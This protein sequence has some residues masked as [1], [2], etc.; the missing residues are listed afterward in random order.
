MSVLAFAIFVAM[1][2]PSNKI[3][4]ANIKKEVQEA[5]SYYPELDSAPIEFKFKKEIKKSTMQAQPVFRS[6]FRPKMKRA[7]VVLISENI[8]ITDKEFKTKDIPFDVMVGWFGHE[9]GHIKDYQNRNSLDLLFYGLKYLFSTSFIKEA[10][11]TADTHAVNSGMGKY[12]LA[13]KEFIL[14]HAEISEKY[15]ERLMKFYLSP[16]EIMVMLE[17]LENK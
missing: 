10:E 13:T 2:I 16:E 11:R 1:P 6:L 7:Y 5:L 17:E 14:D 3:I 9:L 8:K 4:P 12:I 15:K